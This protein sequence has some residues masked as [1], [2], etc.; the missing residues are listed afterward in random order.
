MPKSNYKPMQVLNEQ[1]LDTFLQALQN[2]DV[3]RDFF[4]TE[5]M[6]GLRR[7]EVC[8]LMWRDFDANAEMLGEPRRRDS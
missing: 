2:D 3:W 6:T 8:A 1:E 5:L 4:Y 7:G